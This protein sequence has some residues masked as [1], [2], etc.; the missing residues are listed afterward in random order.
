[1][2]G[3]T[4]DEEHVR[5]LDVAVDD[6]PLVGRCE[7]RR[8]LARD[9]DGVVEREPAGRQQARAEVLAVEPLH[10]Q[11]ALV[12]ER[13]V[14]QV[15]HDRWMPQSGEGLGLTL[16]API[17]C[18]VQLCRLDRDGSSRVAVEAAIHDARA[19]LAR[20]A[21]DLE[22]TLENVSDVHGD[23]FSGAWC[24]RNIGKHHARDR[25]NRRIR[26]GATCTA[27]QSHGQ[28]VKRPTVLN[29]RFMFARRCAPIGPSYRTDPRRAQ[30]PCIAQRDIACAATA[31]QHIAAL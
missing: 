6:A 16:E 31:M 23:P 12:L 25:P 13:A 5:R 8:D 15:A 18:T 17:G 1:V 9:G 26:P 7:R 3:P 30:D 28:E 29:A 20:D 24:S 10:H 19:A 11:V 22:P 27:A 14:P 4:A 2:I 21:L